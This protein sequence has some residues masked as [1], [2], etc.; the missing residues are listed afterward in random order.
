MGIYKICCNF[1]EKIAKERQRSQREP[2]GSE[3]ITKMSEKGAKAFQKGIQ[4]DQ[5][6]AN[7]EP[8]WAKEG[9]FKNMNFGTGS[10][11]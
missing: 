8:K 7:M 11:K 9:T 1:R 4:N 2:K 10:K 5:H 3:K 6:G